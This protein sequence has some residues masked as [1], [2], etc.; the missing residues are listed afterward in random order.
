MQ[1]VE[2]PDDGGTS[3]RRPLCFRDQIVAPFLPW[4]AVY[5]L[6]AERA[7]DDATIAS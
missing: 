3:R 5:S 1:S 4:L 7:Y 6:R 2:A